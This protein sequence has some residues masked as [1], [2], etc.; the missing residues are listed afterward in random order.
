MKMNKPEH[1]LKWHV[2]FSKSKWQPNARLITEGDTTL[3]NP[4]SL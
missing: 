1:D 2:T 3:E 4:E